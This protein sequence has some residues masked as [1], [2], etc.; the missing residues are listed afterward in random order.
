MINSESIQN[1]IGKSY[2]VMDENASGLDTC[3]IFCRDTARRA[4]IRMPDIPSALMKI[5]RAEVGNVVLFKVGTG[6]HC[7]L[8]WPDGLH[9]VHACPEQKDGKLIHIIRKERLTLWPWNAALEGFY[10]AA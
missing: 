7:G 2:L 9:F 6:W 5:D 8:V 1:M 3:W 10:C 4:N